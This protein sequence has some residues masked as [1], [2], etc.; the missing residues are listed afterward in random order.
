MSFIYRAFGVI[1]I[2]Y[3]VKLPVPQERVMQKGLL[4]PNCSLKQRTC[5]QE[6]EKKKTL[7]IFLRWVIAIS[8]G[9]Y[10]GESI[11]SQSLLR[12]CSIGPAAG[13]S[14]LLKITLCNKAKSNSV[15]FL[16]IFAQSKSYSKSILLSPQC[17]WRHRWEQSLCSLGEECKGTDSCKTVT[18]KAR[19]KC[20]LLFEVILSTPAEPW[21]E[22]SSIHK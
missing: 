18:Q 12:P 15:H 16:S 5:I 20:C 22:I 13:T 3:T 11:L 21:Q 4:Q 9:P 17:S 8:P 19:N 7:Q 1:N 10:A 6:I 14:R 2:L